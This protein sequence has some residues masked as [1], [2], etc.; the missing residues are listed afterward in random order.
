MYSIVKPHFRVILSLNT[1]WVQSKCYSLF[2]FSLQLYSPQTWNSLHC[3]SRSVNVIHFQQTWKCI[4]ILLLFVK[5]TWTIYLNHSLCL[6]VTYYYWYSIGLNTFILPTTAS[7]H[8]VTAIN[9]VMNYFV[10][11]CKWYID[12]SFTL[13]FTS[14]LATL[15]QWCIVKY[16]VTYCI[17]FLWLL[18]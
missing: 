2:S 10:L 4:V 18:W 3:N 11:A 7:S 5:L 6:H 14:S 12:L 13:W 8:D 1:Y 15:T 17:N 16:S 9:I